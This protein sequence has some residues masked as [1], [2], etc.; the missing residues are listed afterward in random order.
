MKDKSKTKT[1]L[2]K[3]L[4]TL[5]KQLKSTVKKQPNKTNQIQIEDRLKTIINALPDVTF[6]LDEDGRYIEVLTSEYDLLYEELQKIKGNLIQDIIPKESADLFLATIHKTITTQENQVLEY[7]LE[8]PSGKVQFEGRTSPLKQ[9]FHNKKAIIWIAR[10]ITQNKLLEEQLRHSQKIQSIGVLA[11]GIAHEFNNLLSPILGNSDM[12][13]TEPDLK[14]EFKILLQDIYQSGKRAKT[15]V[16]QIL[17]FSQQ[18]TFKRMPIQFEI[19]VK[20]AL[21]FI[22]ST[23]SPN[24]VI[25]PLNTENLP[26]ILANP[27]EIHQIIVNLCINSSHAMPHGGIINIS[28]NPHKFYQFINIQG[29][30][31]SGSFICLTIQDSGIG[32]H[33]DDIEHIFD[34]FFTTKK[35]GQGTGLGLSVALGII[36][37]HHGHI[38]VDSQVDQ[39]TTFCI[40]LPIAEDQETLPLPEIKPAES[41]QKKHI[42]MI[43]DEEIVQ[44]TLLRMLENIGYQA[45]GFIECSTVIKQFK[46]HPKSFDLVITDYGM[47]DMTGKEL[48]KKLK[49]IRPDIPVILCTGYDN[50]KKENIKTWGVDALL[51]KPFVQDELKQVI[52]TVLSKYSN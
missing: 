7:E 3:E 38:T 45:T 19:I 9:E 32:I 36:E 31:M 11:G 28:L 52:N 48:I 1:Q 12:L 8:V 44:R 30:T 26:A 39:G 47:P 43:D 46:S 13:L 27:A 40:Y 23:I 16:Q 20:E 17:T 24:I 14:H 41:I 18:T 4:K 5:R 51:I 37:Q 25:K 49:K 22:K 15:L 35:I 10:D 42:L 33:K 29:K 6:I 2:I 50:L 21:T 34:P